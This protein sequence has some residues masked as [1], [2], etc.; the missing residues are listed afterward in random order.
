MF[1]VVVLL[2]FWAT[3]HLEAGGENRNRLPSDLLVD[4]AY[5]IHGELG[6]AVVW[7]KVLCSVKLQGEVAE[8][9]FVEEESNFGRQSQEVLRLLLCH[10]LEL[11]QR[12]WRDMT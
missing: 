12:P 5:L 1:F 9:I 4:S 7:N 11:G 6:A 10:L 3:Y 8:Q 2:E